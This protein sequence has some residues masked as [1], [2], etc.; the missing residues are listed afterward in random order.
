[1]RIINCIRVLKKIMISSRA[2]QRSKIHDKCVV[3]VAWEG[4]KG[5]AEM[6]PTKLVGI[7]GDLAKQE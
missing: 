7:F 1:M 3:G 4:T 5:E 6:L 2:H